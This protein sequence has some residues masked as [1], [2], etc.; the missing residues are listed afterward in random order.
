RAG[1]EQMADFAER[2][3]FRGNDI[4]SFQIGPVD[5]PALGLGQ[6]R[7]PNLDRRAYQARRRITIVATWQLADQT[8][9]LFAPLRRFDLALCA[10]NRHQPWLVAEQRQAR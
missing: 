4:E 1:G 10:S 6:N 2:N 7:T 5:L 9:A 8:F 3:A